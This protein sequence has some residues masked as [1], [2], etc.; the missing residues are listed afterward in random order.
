LL[1]PQKFLLMLLLLPQKL[2]PVL[3]LLLQTALLVLLL[4][5]LSYVSCRLKKAIMLG[6]FLHIH[7]PH[8]LLL[9]VVLRVSPCTSTP[10]LPPASARTSLILLLLLLLLYLCFLSISF[11]LNSL[12]TRL[13]LLGSH[14]SPACCFLFSPL[15]PLVMLKVSHHAYVTQVVC[16]VT[17]WVTLVCPSLCGSTRTTTTATATTP[18]ISKAAGGACGGGSCCTTRSPT[19]PTATAKNSLIILPCLTNP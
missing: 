18:T 2:R 12:N 17:V 9:V 13:L 8:L 14:S 7:V 5:L 11:P 10:P 4:L 16:E 1:L 19:L 15:C 6:P 3:L